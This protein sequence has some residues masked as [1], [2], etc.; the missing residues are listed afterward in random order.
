[1]AITKTNCSSEIMTFREEELFTVPKEV[2]FIWL[3][4]KIFP[5]E[6]LKNIIKW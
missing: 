1:M 2:H 6:N 5:L 4:H 3:G